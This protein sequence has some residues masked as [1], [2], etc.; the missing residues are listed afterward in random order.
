MEKYNKA[1]SFAWI[2]GNLRI[3]SNVIKVLIDPIVY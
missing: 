2:E 1:E 3:Q